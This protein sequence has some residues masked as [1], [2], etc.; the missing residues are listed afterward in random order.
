M[1]NYGYVIIAGWL[2]LI[3]VWVFGSFT[4]KRDASSRRPSVVLWLFRLLCLGLLT[5]ALTRNLHGDAY[6]LEQKFLD[7]GLTVDWVGACLTIVGI[8][9]AIWARFHLGR[10]WGAQPKENHV[11]ETSGPY[12]YVRHPIY[13]GA[14]LALFGSA[15]TGSIVAAA[16]FIISI[17]FCLR[18]IPNEERTMFSVFP[19]QYPAYRVRTTKRLIPFVW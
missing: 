7:F 14:I 11:L 10:D 8:V 12:A 4:A 17:V 19:N 2:V 18:R 3:T 5:F 6:V 9:F 16:L 1:H 15:L 13:A